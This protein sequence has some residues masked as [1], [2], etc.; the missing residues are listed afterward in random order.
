MS[1][2]SLFAAQREDGSYSHPS[3]NNAHANGSFEAAIAMVAIAGSDRAI[4]AVSKSR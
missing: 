2:F 4:K 1:R 3:K